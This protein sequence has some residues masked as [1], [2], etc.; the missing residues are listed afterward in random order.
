MEAKF[1]IKKGRQKGEVI[2]ENSKT[3]WVKFKY[4]KNI[5]DEGAEAI[6]KKFIAIIKRHRIK[7]N[8]IIMG[9]E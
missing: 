7:H 1:N 9:V 3:I 8:V 6:F 4:K 5:A 2:K